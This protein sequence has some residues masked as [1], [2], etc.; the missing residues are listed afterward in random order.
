MHFGRYV[1]LAMILVV[2]SFT[3]TLAMSQWRLQL[4]IRGIG[5]PVLPR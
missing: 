1:A 3:A 4:N 2:A 5:T